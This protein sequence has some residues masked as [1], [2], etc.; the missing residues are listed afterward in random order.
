M[1]ALLFVLLFALMALGAP[2]WVAMATSGVAYVLIADLGEATRLP[3][4]MVDGVS[5]FE[6]L[7]VPF[8]ILTGD[9]MNRSG[10]TKR[11]I[12][13]VLFFIGKVRGALAYVSVSVSLF[14]SGISGSAP[15]DA[16][17]V[18]AVLMPAMREEGYRPT[19]AASVNAA[20]AIIGPIMPPSIPM[21]FVALV[22][23]LSVGQLF[24]GGVGPALLLTAIL[25]VVLFLRGR[26]Q[27]MP[28]AKPTERSFGSLRRLLSEALMALVAPVIIVGGVLTGV[29]TVTEL[30]FVASGYVLLVGILIYRTI[31]LRDLWGIFRDNA[32]FASTVM[33]LFA[34]V[35][36][37]S[38][39]VAAERVGDDLA[40]LVDGLDVGPVQFLL[41]AMVFF[42]VVGLVIDAVPAI[43]IFAPILLPAALDVGVDPI[44]FGVVIVVNLMIGL[45]TPP[46]GALLYVVSKVS[47]VSFVGLTRQVLPFVVALLGG[48]VIIV[49]VPEIVMWLPEAIFR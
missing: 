9:L 8:F 38:Y 33:V 27:P 31:S 4:A 20:S 37:F 28:V 16:S 10:M 32:V 2:V 26:H 25:F 35:G 6:L 45:L 3:T 30:A 23:N 18:S 15:A 42:L 47:Q 19:F 7:A 48:L 14:A 34:V 41:L 43:L 36:I 46:V 22:T 39:I 17:A 44:H 24:L 49:L 5:G 1:I 29:A 40:T 12:D 13:L 11:L 21:I